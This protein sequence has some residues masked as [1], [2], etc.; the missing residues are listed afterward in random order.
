N[1]A[2]FGLVPG[3][4]FRCVGFT[5]TVA[6]NGFYRV[7]SITGAGPYNVFCDVVPTGFATDAA[8]GQKIVVSFTDYVRNG[9]TRLAH[10]T[11]KAFLDAP[12]VIYDYRT[13]DQTNQ[14]TLDLQHEQIVKLNAACIA[15]DTIAPSTTV[16]SGATNVVPGTSPVMNASTGLSRIAEALVQL[17]GGTQ[18]LPLG[19]KIMIN[20]NLRPQPAAGQIAL[21]G[22]GFG[23]LEIT[24][25]FD[26][27]L[28]TP[29][30]LTKLWANTTSAFD[31]RYVDNNGD[32]YIWDIP[33]IKYA[34]GDTPM[35]AQ[36]SD[37]TPK[38]AFRGIVTTPSAGN[39]YV[40]HVQRFEA[41]A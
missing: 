35:P 38:M 10:A 13:G 41:V 15:M 22:I 32:G 39:A 29:A 30:M 27:Y 26:V 19:A 16:F 17:N 21:A 11:E 12:A 9:T 4:W 36:N 24:G 33:T 5:G 18:N 7:S 37:V 1:P 2:T 14:L 28:D 34:D 8:A 25:E 31:V 40:I 6:N 20:G 3:M 23:T